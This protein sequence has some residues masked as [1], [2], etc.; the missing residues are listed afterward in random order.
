VATTGAV[1][2]LALVLTVV[3]P[4]VLPAVA[5]DASGL[6]TLAGGLLPELVQA[7]ADGRRAPQAVLRSRTDIP[8]EVPVVPAV[9]APKH[10]DPGSAATPED[11]RG[12]TRLTWPLPASCTDVSS[13]ARGA[14]PPRLPARTGYSTDPASLGK[15]ARLQRVY[16]VRDGRLSPLDG[17]GPADRCD[18]WR[19]EV[20]RSGIPAAHLVALDQVMLYDYPPEVLQD[21]SRQGGIRTGFFEPNPSDPTRYRLA[22]ATGLGAQEQLLTM[23]HEVGH[24]VS[25]YPDRTRPSRDP[26]CP[27]VIDNAGTC[28]A[29]GTPLV[30]FYAGTCSAEQRSRIS[31]LYADHRQP[32]ADELQAFHATGP[33]S[34]VSAYAATHPTE[35]FAESYAYW[36]LHGTSRDAPVEGASTAGLAKRAFFDAEARDGRLDARVCGPWRALASR[37]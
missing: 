9:A 19:W 5:R 26:R 27:W 10:V 16:A 3:L 1:A 23:A 31:R 20:L 24:L 29:A 8:R 25:L 28:A 13:R 30:A 18:R 14:R 32:S 15:G 21:P 6:R 33:E 11:V 4:V 34:F 17:L 2:A 12:A 36:C 7:R 22:F 37:G 35:D